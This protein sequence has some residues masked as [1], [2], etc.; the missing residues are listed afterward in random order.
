MEECSEAPF[1]SLGPL[2]ID[3]APGYDHITSV[4]GAAMA[5]WHDP[6]MHCY[7]TPKE[8]LGMPN[9]EHVREGLIAYTIAAHAADIARHRLVPAIAKMSSAGPFTPSIGTSSLSFLSI[10]SG[11]RSITRKPWQL[12]SKS[13]QSFAR[14]VLP[15][16]AQFRPRS[17]MP[18]LRACK[19]CSRVKA[20]LS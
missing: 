18:T 7:F 4:I 12:T 13:R 10:L 2:V 5:S 19:K 9:A 15:S 3:I 14:C 1:Y 16:T 17:P 8:H 11:P 20:G 6:A